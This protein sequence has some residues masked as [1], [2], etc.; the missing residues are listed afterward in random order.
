MIDFW[1]ILGRG[2][3]QGVVPS[4]PSFEGFF[5]LRREDLEPGSH[6]TLR[7]PLRGAADIYPKWLRPPRRG[8]E[9]SSK[10]DGMRREFPTRFFEPDYSEVFRRGVTTA[11][12]RLRLESISDDC[13]SFF[14]KFWGQVGTLGC[15]RG[16]PWPQVPFEVD[17][18]RHFGAHGLPF[19][20]QWSQKA[21]SRP[22]QSGQNVIKWEL[23]IHIRKNHRTK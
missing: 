16:T 2:R 12:F 5:Q 23:R 11:N 6:I 20:S 17:F 22:S 1:R 21:T 3:R 4:R 10:K 15:P 8:W 14:E 19:G 7:S 9:V 13:P 18:G